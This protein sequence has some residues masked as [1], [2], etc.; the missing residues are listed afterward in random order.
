[1]LDRERLA[2]VAAKVAAVI[3]TVTIVVTVSPDITLRGSFELIM[4]E[5]CNDCKTA[6]EQPESPVMLIVK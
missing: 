2:I 5:D 1:M 6:L 4:G 3:S